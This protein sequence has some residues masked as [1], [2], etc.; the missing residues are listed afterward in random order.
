MTKQEII[1]EIYAL[2]YA[3]DL[4]CDIE[5]SLNKLIEY[6]EPAL[7]VVGQF[8][9]DGGEFSSNAVWLR[10]FK[11][12]EIQDSPRLSGDVYDWIRWVIQRY[13][14]FF[15]EYSRLE[16]AADDYM[17]GFATGS[18]S[19]NNSSHR[20]T[21]VRNYELFLKE[22]EKLFDEKKINEIKKQIHFLQ[23]G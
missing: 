20:Q 21:A 12:L 23:A 1:E 10:Y 19:Y 14:V 15:E 17:D 9:Y 22:T 4:F 6:G 11:E 13:L 8:F 16:K 18:L 2:E 7:Y 5:P 3:V